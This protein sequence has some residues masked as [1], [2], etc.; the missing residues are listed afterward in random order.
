MRRT[1][2]ELINFIVKKQLKF[3]YLSFLLIVTSIHVLKGQ[4]AENY[5]FYANSGIYS[6]LNGT[7]NSLSGGTVN[8]GW[9]NG[10]PIGFTFNYCGTN[11]TYIHSSTNGWMTFGT[12]S[13]NNTISNAYNT[14]NLTSGGR[15]P[16]VAPLWDDLNLQSN[17]NFSYLTTGTS[18]NRIFTAEWLNTRW[19]NSA[20]GNTISFQVKLYETSNKIEFI[21]RPESGNVASPSASIGI[22]NL[23]TG[24]GN[25][26]S[27]NGTG[28]NPKVS[29]T[30]ET[31]TL[32]TK[33]ADGQKYIFVPPQTV[34][35]CIL[36][37]ED[38]E[39][40]AI[41][42]IPTTGT[43]WRSF[44][45]TT[46]VNNWCFGDVTGSISGTRSLT[47]NNYTYNKTD[48]ANKVA[49]YG[50]KIN[51]RDFHNLKMD[52]K[53][54]CLGENNNDYGMLVWSTDGTN[55]QSVTSTRYFGQTTTQN[56]INLDLSVCDNKEF[57]IGFRWI[58]NNSGGTNPPFTLDDIYIKG[59]PY[60]QYS[61]SYRQDVFNNITN[62]TALSLDANGGASVTLPF[63]FHYTNNLYNDIRVSKNGWIKLGATDPGN[64]YNNNLGDY[65]YTPFLAPLWDSLTYDAFSAILYKTIGTSPNRVFCIEW[66]NILWGNARQNFQVKLSETTGLIEFCYGQMMEPFNSTATI[67]INDGT[68]CGSRFL[69]VTPD[70]APSVSAD[71]SNDYISS[72]SYLNNGLVYI[73]NPQ[74]MQYYNTWQSA[75]IVVGQPDFT[76]QNNSASQTIAAGANS[77]TVSSKGILAVGAY[78]TNR[79]LLWNSIPTSNG[80][81]ADVVIGQTNFNSTNAGTT[82]STLNGPYN[83]AFSPDGIKMLVADAGNNRILIWNTVPT[84]NGVPADVVIGQTNFTSS[85]SGVS[86]TQLNTP[87]GIL[88]LPNGKLIITDNENNRVLIYN[89]IPTTN[90]KVADV[91]I[92]QQNFTTNTSGSGANK[93]DYPWDVAYSPEG[94]LLISDNGDQD[95]GNHRILIFNEVPTGTVLFV[96]T[97]K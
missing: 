64:I 65:A 79:V 76:T 26:L 43:S 69:S 88:V 89:S 22:C 25:F 78:W 81:P 32:N 45:Q 52:F 91:V 15:R 47:I 53:W 84:S 19:N 50:T 13:T 44:T 41:G 11:Y 14:N 83:V 74:A 60:L 70:P 8:D 18:P 6:V 38:F 27:L 5:N 90:G 23:V 28:S 96:A 56:I 75:N 58:N 55:W 72:V 67:G 97:I 66:K 4:N 37:S 92:G 29:S 48:N 93:F 9:F 46:S 33:P 2:P 3:F 71:N 7:T 16:L 51:A 49:Y 87:S 82:A 39:S 20:T 62:G 61:F 34:T 94:K 42:N 36:F 40:Y 86:A 68:Y 1:L 30:T 54:K 35:S 73:F 12:S 10:I 31:T 77:S 80:V 17:T 63:P 24:S 59:T 95:N 57:F 21:Y 85:G